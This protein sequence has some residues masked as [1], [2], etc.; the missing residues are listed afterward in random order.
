MI[1]RDQI[2]RVLVGSL[3]DAEP[4]NKTFELSVT[5]GP[6]KESL[7]AN[8]AAFRAGDTDDIYGILDSNIVPVES[9]AP[10]F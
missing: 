6:A 10:L 7:T 3:N 1:A 4:R 2:T 9:T 5:Y 8:F